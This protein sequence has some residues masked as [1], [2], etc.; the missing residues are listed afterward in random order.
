MLVILII[1]VILLFYYFYT[2]HFADISIDYT[3]PKYIWGYWDDLE[4]NSIIQSHI[5]TWKR[6]ISKD[7]TIV[8]LDKENV[9][10]YVSN[11]FMK[12]YSNLD[13]TRFSDFLRLELLQKYGGVW[14]DASIIITNGTFLDQYYDEMLKNKY[15]ATV[16]ELEENTIDKKTPYLENWFIMAPKN[17]KYIN[18]IYK[19]FDKALDMGFINYKKK[20]LIPSGVRL[21]KTLGYYEKTYL[22]QHAIINYLMYNNYKYN[23]NI[24]DSHESMFKVHKEKDWEHPKIINFLEE[25]KDWSNYHGIKLTKQSRVYINDTQKYV[26]NIDK[27]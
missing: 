21:D 17:S 25:N 4:L 23:L 3:L 22:M 5:N 13:S 9:S 18:D 24:K 1:L 20:V 15:D 19:E 10:N 6:K 14:M 8:I 7:W 2:E 12:K 16:Y 11:D 27:I 26:D